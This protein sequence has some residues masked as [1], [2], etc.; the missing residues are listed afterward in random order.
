M[1]LVFATANQNKAKEIQGL[2]PST[3]TI[4]SLNDINCLEEIPETEATIEGNASQ[5]A[6]YVY[7]K[8]HFNCFADDTG[9]EVEALGG[10]PGVFSARYAGESKN[11]DDNMNKILLELKGILNR[12]ARF[13][14]II[15]LVIDGNELQFEGVVNGTIL[16]EKR[17]VNG[18]GYDPIFV[19]DGYDKTFAE[20]DFESKN[21]VSHRAIAVYKLVEYLKQINPS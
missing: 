4:L 19:P 11:A 9:L 12:K 5:K 2:I 7:E 15:S 17:G 6:V 18:F 13:K 14:T 1:K 16:T 8:F 20:M 21:K 10:R 3:I